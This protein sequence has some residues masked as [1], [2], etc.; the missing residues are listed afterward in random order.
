MKKVLFFA[1]LALP[2]CALL[3]TTYQVQAP[4]TATNPFEKSNIF[5]LPDDYELSNDEADP[6]S[7]TWGVAPSSEG[8]GTA[9][10][11]VPHGYPFKVTQIGHVAIVFTA[12]TVNWKNTGSA[13]I[14]SPNLLGEP[15]SELGKTT[16]KAPT[17]PFTEFTWTDISSKNI[18]ITSGGFFAALLLTKDAAVVGYPATCNDFSPPVHHTSWAKL[19]F[20]DGSQRWAPFDS[21]GFSGESWAWGDSVDIMIRV[22]GAGP[23]GIEEE[24]LPVAMTLTPSATIMA[25][26]GM[27]NYFLPEAGAVEITL[28]DASGRLVRNIYSGSSSSGEHSI[29]WNAS[30]LA[31][32]AYFMRLKTSTGV[33]VA[34][35]VLAN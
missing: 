19:T 10:Y 7:G 12:D 2:L 26:E 27:V 3:A 35:V 31:S 15:G 24:L 21:I 33:K 6:L 1:A 16:T 34:K 20:L 18:S 14:L 23:L 13:V 17:T 8:E 22:R 4:A 32:G 11:F 30:T 25:S 29:S 28:W 9:G 5:M